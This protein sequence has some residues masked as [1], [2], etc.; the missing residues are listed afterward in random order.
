M[1]PQVIQKGGEAGELE[2]EGEPARGVWH[3]E[4]GVVGVVRAPEGRMDRLLPEAPQGLL[5]E[6]EKYEGPDN[7]ADREVDRG[8]GVVGPRGR[9]C[10][11]RHRRLHPLEG[12]GHAVRR[13][14]HVHFLLKVAADFFGVAGVCGRVR[15]EGPCI[16]ASEREGHGAGSRN[17][18]LGSRRARG[19]GAT[20]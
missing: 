13:L 18:G 17:E 12:V 4:S 16:P 19:T 14:P 15:H 10:V 7:D 6:G 2:A 9:L 20:P 1:Q 5:E 8:G 3:V 11:L